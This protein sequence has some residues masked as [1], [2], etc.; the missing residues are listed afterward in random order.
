M[1]YRVIVP[2]AV[3]EPFVQIAVSASDAVAKRSALRLLFG[4]SEIRVERADGAPV[5]DEQLERE[6]ALE[7][8]NTTT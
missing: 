7:L 2:K 5:S 6:R 3:G 1:E 8:L 4:T